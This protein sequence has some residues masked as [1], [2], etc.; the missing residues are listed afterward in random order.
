LL[1]YGDGSE[2]RKW[3]NLM[4]TFL[5]QSAGSRA[6]PA[7]LRA[8][9][10]LL[11]LARQT[12]KSCRQSSTSKTMKTQTPIARITC[13]KTMAGRLGTACATRLLPLL[14]LLLPATV[15][16]QFNYTNNYGIWTYTTTNGTITITG[17]TGPGGAVIIPDRIP[18]T[19]NGLPVTSI[20]DGAF[21]ECG[22]LTSVTIPNSV[23]SIGDFA[24][25]FCTSLTAITV[26]GL[27]AF[28][29]SV[30]G[31]LFN[32]SQTTLI[33][34]PEGKAGSY[35]IPNGVT[36]I[37][38]YAFKSCISLTSVTIPNSVTSIGDDAFESCWSLNSVTIPNSVTSIGDHAFEGSGLTSVT[39][40]TNVTSIGDWAFAD[41]DLT[42]VIIPNRVTNIGDSAFWD[43]TSPSSSAI[44][45][46][47]LN[48]KLETAVNVG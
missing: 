15:Q 24:F 13:P 4:K 32:K 18:D 9:A 5:N 11:R 19:T 36:S 48:K 42:S 30:N 44:F 22:G 10:T 20:G 12:T 34:C 26:D 28:Y 14:L 45:L 47:R 40:G 3:L 37:G 17:Y 27:N 46:R 33:Q 29:S 39:I 38:V 8:A 6:F 1:L 41:C 23:T 16:A 2:L 31:V 25:E 7:G 21:Y 35:T 43:C